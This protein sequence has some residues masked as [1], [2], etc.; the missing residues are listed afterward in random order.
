MGDADILKL[1]QWLS[2]AFPVGGFAYSHGLETAISDGQVTD[3]ASLELWL[4]TVIA[5]GTGR[6][7]AA[8]LCAAMRADADIP[9]LAA[10]AEAL[11]PSKERW[12]ETQEQGAAFGAAHG[13]IAGTQEAPVPLPIAVGRA[14]GALSLD[15]ARVAALYLQSFASN[16]VSCAVRF[17]PLGQ[18]SGQRVLANLHPLVMEVAHSASLIAPQDVTSTVPGA[19]FAA[20]RHETQEVRIFKS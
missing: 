15:G 10:W 1:T 4:S 5:K 8:L 20:M 16:L 3:P 9:A 18:T 14:A 17:V 19:D 13:A 2:P 6:A 12:R 11:A 7:D